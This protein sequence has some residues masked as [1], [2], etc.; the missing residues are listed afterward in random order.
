MKPGHTA[1]ILVAIFVL[2]CVAAPP[3]RVLSAEEQIL[4]RTGQP[5]YLK[6][7]STCDCARFWWLIQAADYIQCDKGTW[8][9]EIP[10]SEVNLDRTFG[11]GTADRYARLRKHG[12][13]AEPKNVDP[14]SSSNPPAAEASA[15]GEKLK[16]NDGTR[17]G[18]LDVR[19][20]GERLDSGDAEVVGKALLELGYHTDDPAAG[21]LIPRLICLLG[22]DRGVSYA[23][24]SGMTG[25][26]YLEGEGTLAGLAG[27]LLERMGPPAAEAI[28]QALTRSP[29]T[30]VRQRM[31]HILSVICIRESWSWMVRGIR[32]DE[33]KGIRLSAIA[34]FGA[35]R[36][37]RALPLLEDA[38]GGS[39]RRRCAVVEAMG[40]IGDSR[41]LPFLKHVLA[42]D[43]SGAVR[44]S[45]TRSLGEI[46]DPAATGA[47]IR[48]SE[49]ENQPGSSLLQKSVE[50]AVQNALADT[51]DAGSLQDLVHALADGNTSTRVAAARALARLEDP[52]AASSLSRAL[53]SD[54]DARVR[55]CAVVGLLDLQGQVARDALIRALQQESEVNIRRLI[56]TGLRDHMHAEVVDALDRAVRQDSDSKVRIE[57]MNSILHMGELGKR[58]ADA[59][60]YAA[61]NDPAAYNRKTAKHYL[62]HIR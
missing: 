57:A 59:L 32:Q 12:G 40:S 9:D 5:I 44:A 11:K 50:N 1:W 31:Y 41:A 22:D 43:E 36:D 35:M 62:E 53:S 30:R 34:Y 38:F 29:A 13:P 15:P 7:G 8:A 2:I 61:E 51:A 19:D 48:A 52:A 39:T 26:P 60:E 3:S 23:I 37:S 17:S 21:A 54:T 24:Y 20:I 42:N 16:G 55:N 28:H 46:G 49:D 6:D 47:L 45:A 25:R 58:A 14:E 27:G 10:V 56:A 18:D 4:M 33:E